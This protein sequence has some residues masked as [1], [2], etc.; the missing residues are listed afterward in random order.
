MTK[1]QS[2][3]LPCK[4]GHPANDHYDDGNGDFAACDGEGCDCN[5]YRTNHGDVDPLV[6]SLVRRFG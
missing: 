5:H 6:D 1:D 2:C 4:C 3:F